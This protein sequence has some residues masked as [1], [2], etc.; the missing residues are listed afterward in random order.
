MGSTRFPGKMSMKF[1]EDALLGYVLENL[2]SWNSVAEIILATSTS[3][4]DTELEAIARSKGIN[5]YRGEEHN[6]A[7]RLVQAA[8]S[9]QYGTENSRF[10]R[11]CADNPFLCEDLYLELLEFLEKN[12]QIDYLSHKVNET[13]A[14]LT[15]HGMFIEY[16]RLQTLSEKLID[17][18]AMEQEHATLRFLDRGANT[19]TKFLSYEWLLDG[20]TRL[21]CDTIRDYEMLKQMALKVT[22]PI[23]TAQVE[24]LVNHLDEDVLNS[25]EQQRKANSKK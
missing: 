10:F 15:D 22:F 2:L 4:T 24:D 19:S 7:N 8:K 25:M 16:F 1:G 3:E 14:I 12:N 6:V 20:R 11:V 18:T 17:L 13:P 23:T 9:S 21:T 5:V